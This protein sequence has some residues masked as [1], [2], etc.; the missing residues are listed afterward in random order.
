MI[1]YPSIVILCAGTRPCIC[2]NGSDTISLVNVA[3]NNSTSDAT[4]LTD[5]AAPDN[6]GEANALVEKGF[7]CYNAGDYACAWASFESAHAI[8]P[9]DTDIFCYH[10]YL[11]SLQKHESEALEKIDA[12]LALEPENPDLLYEKG[13]I[14]NSMGRYIESGPYFDRAE[15]L[16]PDYAVPLT[17]RFPLNLFVKNGAV[18]VVVIGFSLLGIDIYIKERRR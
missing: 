18:I 3:E 10:G 7:L 14:L 12:G 17:A 11:L 13:T 2:Y 4:I 8:L 5:T 9:D 16:D 6:E 15:E 1:I